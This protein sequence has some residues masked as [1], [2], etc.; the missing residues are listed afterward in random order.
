NVY[1][2]DTNNNR[3][4][5]IPSG[6]GSAGCQ[7]TVASSLNQPH[8]IA[9]D[10]AGNLYVAETGG[11]LEIS[12][13]QTSFLLTGTQLSSNAPLDVA[14]DQSGSLYIADPTA[15]TVSELDRGD[16]PFVVFPGAV[17]V[18]Q[19]SAPQNVIIENIGTSPLTL[20]DVVPNFNTAVDGPQS[21]CAT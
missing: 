14:L 19:V 2:S 7:T 1:V 5:K 20:S 15:T 8:G 4:V 21:T 12:S 10:A 6:C 9:V 16:T 13:T 11:V 17:S 18:G 3:V